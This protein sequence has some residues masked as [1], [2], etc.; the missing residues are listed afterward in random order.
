MSLG[1][2]R[3]CVRLTTRYGPLDVLGMIGKQRDFDALIVKAR[4]RRLGE[5]SV[6]VLDLPTQ[7]AAKK[8]LGFATEQNGVEPKGVEPST[9]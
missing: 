8:K 3:R 9:S 1:W 5:F 6:W 4:R 2:S 7:I